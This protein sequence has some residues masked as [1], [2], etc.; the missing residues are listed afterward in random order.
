MSTKPS[1]YT[2][3]LLNAYEEIVG[4]IATDDSKFYYDALDRCEE[5]NPAELALLNCL[6]ALIRARQQAAELRLRR[7]LETLNGDLVAKAEARALTAQQDLQKRRSLQVLVLQQ[8]V[9]QLQQQLKIHANLLRTG[10]VM[11][12]SASLEAS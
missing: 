1:G 2:G 10:E 5:A 11:A 7:E 9:E 6:P 8:Q 4:G 3:V 12:S